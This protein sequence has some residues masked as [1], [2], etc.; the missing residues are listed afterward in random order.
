M[1]QTRSLIVGLT[2]LPP[3]S[4]E[5]APRSSTRLRGAPVAGRQADLSR[6]QVAGPPPIKLVVVEAARRTSSEAGRCGIVHRWNTLNIE[7]ETLRHHQTSNLRFF[8]LTLPQ[9]MLCGR[10]VVRLR[11]VAETP[12]EHR[13]L[14]LA[15][16]WLAVD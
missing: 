5:S 3:P 13:R 10:I 12:A 9:R 15:S 11:P 7:T 4:P 1:N 6:L 16:T 8:L 14:P 2:L